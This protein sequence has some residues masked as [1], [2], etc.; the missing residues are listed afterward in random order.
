MMDEE[1]IVVSGLPR[2][3]TSMM[4]SMLDA[5]GLTPL[6]DERRQADEDNPRGYWEDDRV[7]RLREDNS[8][9]GEACGQVVKVISVLLPHLP[10]Q[11]RYRVI[12][13]ERAL[14]EIL[15]SQRKMLERSGQQPAAPDDKMSS[16]YSLHLGK[17]RGWLTS[18]TNIE[19]Q[20]F[21]FSEV[22]RNP[23]QA[24]EDIAAFLKRPLDITNMVSVVDAALYRK[25]V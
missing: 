12:F 24:A 21:S 25:R 15:A 3:G 23:Q 22:V 19:A 10:S 7:K 14:P 20:F 18:Q 4:M 16:F 1:I 13:M 11:F 9:V 6:K 17:I 5:G 8:W 2:S